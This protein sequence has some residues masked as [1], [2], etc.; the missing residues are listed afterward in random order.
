MYRAVVLGVLLAAC[1]RALFD[2]EQFV[3]VAGDFG[4]CSDGCTSGVQTR[5]VECRDPRGRAVPESRCSGYAKPEPSRACA[6]TACAWDM[7]DWDPCPVNCGGGT[8]MRVVECVTASGMLAPD[9]YCGGTRPIDMQTC[10][11]QACCRDVPN[12]ESELPRDPVQMC[13]G[14]FLR[15][16]INPDDVSMNQRCIELG[17]DGYGGYNAPFTFMDWCYYCNA[18][19][20]YWDGTAWVA[21]NCNVGVNV[22]RCCDTP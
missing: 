18:R 20:M 11:T 22:M 1:G 12:N 3:W 15:Y 4:L 19:T 14:A 16:M 10:N 9:A 6:E 17:F 8:Q 13:S 2:D 21:N 7:T 5:A